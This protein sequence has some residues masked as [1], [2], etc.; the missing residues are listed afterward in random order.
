[1]VSVQLLSQTLMPC[2]PLRLGVSYTSFSFIL[3][4]TELCPHLGAEETEATQLCQSP[5]F[6]VHATSYKRGIKSKEKL[7]L[8]WSQQDRADGQLHEECELRFVGETRFEYTDP[9]RGGRA[10]KAA[11]T[12]LRV[13]RW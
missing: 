8:V 9:Q 12:G 11:E 3:H 1:M 7:T 6:T 10:E 13:N 2:L 4:S 5:N